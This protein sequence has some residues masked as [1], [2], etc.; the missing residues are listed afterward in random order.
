MA[1]SMRLHSSICLTTKT[2]SMEITKERWFPHVYS[3]SA[4]SEYKDTFQD[5]VH[6]RDG[7]CVLSGLVN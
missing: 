1:L 3:H 5:G 4:N 7:K 6:M 2:G